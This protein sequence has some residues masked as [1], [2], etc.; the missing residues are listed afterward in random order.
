MLHST[1]TKKGQ[2]TIPGP[3]RDA[4]H[5]K[6]GDKLTYELDGDRVV[7]RV[8]PGIMSLGGALASDKG[9]GMSFAQ[10]RELLA[11]EAAAGSAQ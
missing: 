1:V 5:L 2:T 4:L 6:P 7:V 11:R 8:H 10:I 3:I 9:R